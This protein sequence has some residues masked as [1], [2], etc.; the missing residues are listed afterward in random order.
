MLPT[1]PKARNRFDFVPI[2]APGTGFVTALM[3]RRNAID[4]VVPKSHESTS[5]ARRSRLRAP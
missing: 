1:L 3:P 5:Y 2:L 4:F